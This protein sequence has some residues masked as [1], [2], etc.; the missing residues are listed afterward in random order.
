MWK[1]ISKFKYF[2]HLSLG[3]I[4]LSLVRSVNTVYLP[5]LESREG[6]DVYDPF[7]RFL[8]AVD[9]S[10]IIFILTYGSIVLGFFSSTIQNHTMQDYLNLILTWLKQ[11]EVSLALGTFCTLY[12]FYFMLRCKYRPLFL[13]KNDGGVVKITKGALIRMGEDICQELGLSQTRI[14]VRQKGSKLCWDIY[15]TMSTDENLPG[16]VT[17]LQSRLSRSLETVFGIEKQGPI[18]VIVKGVKNTSP[19]T[20][21]S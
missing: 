9:L 17:T 3:I 18:N 7:L 4:F 15:F 6:F 10:G 5:L 8:P 14:K 2:L 16:L 19:L 1:N 20:H 11:A 13:Y 21:S 12:A